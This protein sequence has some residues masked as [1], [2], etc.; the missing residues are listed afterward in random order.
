M[1]I[2]V[3]VLIAEFTAHNNGGAARQTNDQRELSEAKVARSRKLHI[4]TSVTNNFKKR[5]H[6]SYQFNIFDISV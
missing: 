1:I 4:V 3:S 6:A 5:Q 2:A